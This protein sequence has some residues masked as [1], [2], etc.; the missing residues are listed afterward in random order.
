MEI[1]D[2]SGV[3][4]AQTTFTDPPSTNANFA[5]FA[6]CA[7]DP[8]PSVATNC[9]GGW[10]NGILQSSNSHYG[11]DNVVPQR[12]EVSLPSG[13]S[14]SG[15]TL[16]MR[17][18]ARKGTIHA[19]DSMATWNFTQTTAD[20]NQG[21]NPSDVVSGGA[22]TCAIP[23]DPT[24]V[25]DTGA[26]SATSG[27]QLAGQVVTVYGATSCSVA[28]PV[29]N[30]AVGPGDDYASVTITYSVA[31]LSTGRKVQFL[32]G[33]HTA[34]SLGPRGWG[35]GLGSSFVSGG[36]YHFKWD[37]ADGS[38]IGNRDNQ[39]QGAALVLPD[40]PTIGTAIH[41]ISHTIVTSVPVGTT[42]HDSATMSNVGG[43]NGTPA[44]AVTF[45]WYTDGSCTTLA[46]TSSS[47]TLSS[48]VVD[49]T[50]F[51]Q[52][53]VTAGSYS[54][55]AHYTSSDATKWND[56]D[57]PCEPL[58]VNKVTPDISTTPSVGGTIGI[59]VYDTANVT[60]GDNPTG[61][62]TFKLFDTNDTTCS[63]PAL[64]TD[65]QTLSGGSATSG[66][67]TT[68]SVGTYHWTAT[69]NGDSNNNSVSS[70]CEDETVTT[71]KAT[72]TLTT[73]A[74]GPVTVG[75]NIHD[76]A[77][78]SGG[79]GT[80]G[81]SISFEVFAP[82][83]TI[84]AIPTP[85][86]GGA[87]SGADDYTSANYT[88]SAVGTYR[89]IAY[90]S[91]DGNNNAVNT[92]CNDANELSATTKADTT[93]TT[94]V[95]DPDHT[96]ITDSSVPLGTVVHD[97][98]T[99]GAQVNGF[100]IGGTVTYNFFA[101][102][103]CTPEPSTSQDVGVGSESSTKSGLGAGSY[104]YRATYSGDDNYNGSTGNCEPFSI[105][106]ADLR[107]STEIHNA[108][109]EIV[110]SVPL[111]S[112]IHD[113]ANVG[114]IVGGFDPSGDV[115]FTFFEN[116][117][118]APE[119]ADAGSVEIISGAAQP[120]PSSDKGPL[121]AGS[122][123]FRASYPG[124]DNYN[125]A[126]SDCEPLTVDKSQLSL[127]SEVH[128]SSHADV[129]NGSVPLG[130]IVHDTAKING[131]AVGGFTSPAIT[132]KFYTNGT[133]SAGEA[134]VV[135]TGADEDDATRDR[136][137][138]SSA[139]GAG[140]YSYKAFAA[141][142]SNY[143][144]TDSGCESFTV[145]QGTSGVVTELHKAN[146]DVVSVGS[147]VSLGTVMHDKATVTVS[148][149]FVPTGSV[150][151]TFY[152][153][154]SCDGLGT[155]MGTVALDGASPGVAHPS[156]STAALAA[157]SYSFKASW[158]GDTNYPTGASS[159]ENFNVSKAQLNVT[160]EVH[161]NAH[162][163]KTNSNIPLGSVMHDTATVAGGV[164]G[165]TVP[166]P[167]FNLTSNYTDS[168]AS[169]ASVGN[170]GTDAGNGNAKSANS[171]ALGAGSYAYRASVAGN[172]N[173]LG[174]DS[175]CEP[176]T[177]NQG[178]PTVVTEVHNSSEGVITTETLDAIVHDKATITGIGGFTPSGNVDFT[179]FTNGNCSPTGAGAGAVALD[180]SGAAYPSTT[181]T[182]F[183]AGSYSFKAHYA[184]DGNYAAADSD[185]EPFT[186]TTI[187]INKLANGGNDTFGYTVNGTTNA[188]SSI[189]TTGIPGTGSVTTAVLAGNYTVGETT[190]PSGWS[191]VVLDCGTGSATVSS[192]NSFTVSAG[193]NAICNSENTKQN[194]TRTQGFWATHTAFANDKWTNAVPGGEKT[195][196]T[197]I[198]RFVDANPS[199]NELMG[200]FWSNI[201]K[202]SSGANR[203]S[204]DK[205]RMVLLQQLLAAL[206]NKYGLGA[207]DSGLIAAA[208]A[209][210]CGTNINAIKNAASA[211]GSFNQSGDTIPLGF[212][213]PSAT[214]QTSKSQAD[215]PFWN[216]TI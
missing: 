160:T 83:D 40:S 34:A 32:F 47:F 207:A 36:P 214:P 85:V 146:E 199:D 53:P 94:Q 197:G 216:T 80:L 108:A 174:D 69:Y 48:G 114:G 163:D 145:N 50:T 100:V 180:G 67:Y 194:K 31:S 151:F 98:A 63:N 12:A 101:N 90:Y 143:L 182:L 186:Y 43:A 79:L 66:N 195:F 112:I 124:D 74:S 185:C 168:C 78:L 132:F 39:I 22:I 188:V 181:Q 173:Y 111:G 60:G 106:K 37:S 4:A 52:T 142:D 81:G 120:H 196:C 76:V 206:L 178:T 169:G 54:F 147:S 11:E 93:V 161:D 92:T 59:N 175:D 64:F 123:S 129:T 113:Q 183:G 191:S 30:N 1:K 205:A 128:D 158:L 95:H 86:A 121:S 140:P 13:G 165:F 3:V 157:G 212:S 28:A 189:T 179:F 130:S 209:A 49:G 210:Y 171:A 6:Q 41:N 45:K 38:S 51:T 107:L 131:G 7:N 187:T 141:G 213:V 116:G 71:T 203:S 192:S 72:P 211:L 109:H 96:D 88:T 62:V 57:S 25:A 87:V 200:G 148:G 105:E 176:F 89:W 172:D 204:L 149:P 155:A 154:D 104:S 202:T 99:V 139:L 152:S 167:T 198:S 55:N 115:S 170:D 126:I 16:V 5:D 68:V 156:D 14:G 73:T 61:M 150:S 103:N 127:E 84:C 193:T 77:H 138:V 8:S 15:R 117:E 33:G 122:Y 184:G 215:I 201:A 44:G 135:N 21:L 133:C 29:H 26:G 23:S 18:Q 10:I 97:S 56:A 208:K 35:T 65:T 75:D 190:I 20:R 70:N 82:G 164:G 162:T 58:T 91:G 144:G 17:Y 19:Y 159:C 102:G 24:V 177:V 137:A 110:T 119:G 46:A 27:H 166:T 9:P 42:V 134:S 136:S 118:C 2:S 153:N 125:D